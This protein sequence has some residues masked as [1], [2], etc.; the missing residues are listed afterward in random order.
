MTEPPPQGPTPVESEA[1]AYTPGYLAFS[2]VGPQ[3][4]R[5]LS[6]RGSFSG[7]CSYARARVAE[8]DAGRERPPH[9][10]QPYRVVSLEN[11]I[12][13]IYAGL[14]GSTLLVLP[15][16]SLPLLVLSI[17]AASSCTYTDRALT[18]R[19]LAAVQGAED[20]VIFHAG[21]AKLEFWDA[22]IQGQEKAGAWTGALFA[23]AGYGLQL[24]AAA[25]A[26]QLGEKRQANWGVAAPVERVRD[27]LVMRLREAGLTKIRVV[28]GLPN[29][30]GVLV[31]PR[32]LG[33][34]NPKVASLAVRSG[35]WLL[36][37][38]PNTKPNFRMVYFV[39]LEAVR[40]TE[41]KWTHV[42]GCW[43]KP[44]LLEQFEVDGGALAKAATEEIATTCGEYLARQ[45]LGEG[46]KSERSPPSLP[47]A[48]GAG[49]ALP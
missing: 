37:A 40:G 49:P 14:V 48:N 39:T 24:A 42:A 16:A 20:V 30:V 22:R 10:P 1:G 15:R 35:R 13:V 17:L 3:R 46:K 12:R 45:V 9:S 47:R 38:D 36:A 41:L 25:E 31:P 8:R 4:H 7:A 28:Q 11:G 44:A 32:E 18:V 21:S 26:Q 43:S 23:P 29:H 6:A 19:Q 33:D 34:D 5:S 27:H 2:G